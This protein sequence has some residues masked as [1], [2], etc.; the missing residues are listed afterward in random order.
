MSNDPPAAGTPRQL[1]G[2]REVPPDR[3][4]DGTPRVRPRQACSLAK[5]RSAGITGAVLGGPMAGVAYFALSLW[6]EAGRATAAVELIYGQQ[7]GLVSLPLTIVWGAAAC[8]G[9]GLFLTGTRLVGA[10]VQLSAAIGGALLFAGILAG[11]FAGILAGDI[12]TNGP[13]FSQTILYRLPLTVGPTIGGAA[14]LLCSASAILSARR[15]R[16]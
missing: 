5:A 13:D 3:H 10:A 6:A 7:A 1:P 11:D 2:P 9:A 4:A 15:S 16:S 12:E 8:G 14:G